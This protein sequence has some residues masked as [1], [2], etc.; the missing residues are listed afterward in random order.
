MEV[1][2]RG[3]AVT[4]EAF[5]RLLTGRHEANVVKSQRLSSDANSAVL[6]YLSGHGGAEFL[7]FQDSE[8]LSAQDLAAAFHAMHLQSRYAA[9]MLILDTCQAETMAWHMHSPNVL[10]LAASQIGQNSYSHVVDHSIG[11]SLVD[12][13]TF[14][15]LDF[16]EQRRGQ[17]WET[18]STVADL[19]TALQPS[20]LLS[21][22][23][24][25]SDL[26]HTPPQHTPL[27]LF[28]AAEHAAHP[29]R[30]AYT[31]EAQHTPVTTAADHSRVPT[32]ER[33]LSVR[34]APLWTLQL[35]AL[36]V[37]PLSV[38]EDVDGSA[39]SNVIAL[40]APCILTAWWLACQYADSAGFV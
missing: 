3:S 22:P 39:Q 15:L 30:S 26:F 14:H 19:T 13:F 2:Y 33:A 8:E 17:R 38:V 34:A 23:V 37:R 35:R 10:S 27:G 12:R 16:F 20:L 25:R 40:L 21:Q 4:V 5:L 11:L 7:K 18:L 6:I 9:A 32:R 31:A 36:R 1:D 28:F 24:Q 29:Q